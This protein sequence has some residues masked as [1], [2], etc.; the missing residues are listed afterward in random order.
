MRAIL[1]RVR[2]G[3]LLAFHSVLLWA[4]GRTPTELAALLLCARSRVSRLVRA[5][6]PGSLGLRVAPDGQLSSAVQLRGVML[7]R[8]RSLGA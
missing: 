1:R 4:A 8:T 2:E 5:Y 3:S 7:W 6:R